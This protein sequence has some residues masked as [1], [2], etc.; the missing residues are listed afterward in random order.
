MR[1]C[2]VLW[3]FCIPCCLTLKAQEVHFYR[4]DIHF[5]LSEKHITVEGYYYF[6]NTLSDTGNLMLFYPFPLSRLYGKV[7]SIEVVS[8]PELKE[9]P[10]AVTKEGIAFPVTVNPYYAKKY[11]VKYRQ[12]LLSNK[13]EY[14]LLTTQ[15]WRRPLEQANYSL[16]VSPEIFI[17]SMNYKTDTAYVLNNVK[18][19]SWHKKGFVP[20]RDI[21]F[22]FK[23]NRGQR[24]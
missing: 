16:M 8:L 15:Q 5:R 4:E 22:Y 2:L 6:Y 17:D 24:K 11:K 7:D 23:K 12:K 20:D 18:N 21:E 13:A 10:Y 14:I 9:V 1:V 19:Y 3:L